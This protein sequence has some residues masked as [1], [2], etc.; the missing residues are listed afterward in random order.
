MY[1]ECECKMANREIQKLNVEYFN[2]VVGFKN[3]ELNLRRM[4]AKYV[5]VQDCEAI[6]GKRYNNNDAPQ[7]P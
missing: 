2:I 5:N 4:D 7:T 3:K 6:W 1:Q